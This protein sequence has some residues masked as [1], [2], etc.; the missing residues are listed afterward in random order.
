MNNPDDLPILNTKRVYGEKKMDSGII[1]GIIIAAVVVVAVALVIVMTKLGKQDEKRPSSEAGVFLDTSGGNDYEPA[2]IEPDPDMSISFAGSSTPF[3]EEYTEIIA[4]QEDA[5]RF[6]RALEEAS[7]AED[8]N[9]DEP[10]PAVPT[11]RKTSVE[12]KGDDIDEIRIF[13]S[14]VYYI[15]GKMVG[16]EDTPFEMAISGQDLDTAAE[17]DG[18]K[19]NFMR[20]DGKMYIKNQETHHYAVLNSTLMSLLG[21]SNDDFKFSLGKI[22]Y[23]AD[24]PDKVNEVLYNGEKALE[25][26]Y[27]SDDSA[28]VI[29]VADGRMMEVALGDTPDNAKP[30]MIVDELCGDIPE[31]LLTLD[32]YK[33]QNVMSFFTELM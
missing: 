21:V 28:A 29:T 1:L 14:G 6:E 15:K 17:F 10:A 32:G 24:K 16:D 25:Y 5:E 20:L 7:K 11:T 2:A 30:H 27:L 8:Q 12:P 18:K 22:S 23:D 3:N 33:K 26:V 9:E 19:L 4:E 31:G 13:F